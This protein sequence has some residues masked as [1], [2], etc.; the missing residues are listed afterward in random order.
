MSLTGFVGFNWTTKRL[1][2][3]GFTGF[4]FSHVNYLIVKVVD[5]NKIGLNNLTVNVAGALYNTDDKGCVYIA[6]RTFETAFIS[7]TYEGVVFS[8]TYDSSVQTNQYIE[9]EVEPPIPT[10]RFLTT[11]PLKREYPESLP[12][13]LLHF[14]RLDSEVTEL[15][16]KV[17]YTDDTST[18]QT[19]D[20]SEYQLGVTYLTPVRLSSLQTLDPLKT[21]RKI[22]VWVEEDPVIT[23]LEYIIVSDK[24]SRNYIFYY[25]NSMGGLDYLVCEGDEQNIFESEEVVHRKNLHVGYSY[26]EAEFE[27]NNQISR[28]IYEVFTGNKPKKEILALKD[29]IHHNVVHKIVVKDGVN[30]PVPVRL[31]TKSSS[32]P[33][34][35]SNIKNLSF[36]Y[37]YNYDNRTLNRVS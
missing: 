30:I 1:I 8:K 16:V 13:D 3:L 11:K 28:D 2:S 26:S 18:T 14:Q 34:E 21:I 31:I 37:R 10:H 33:S 23:V 12:V 24:S 29:M 19:T 25:K 9:I 7:T 6:N 17:T 15:K 32:L 22:E 35:W 27:V 36:Q 4:S 20:I 5:K